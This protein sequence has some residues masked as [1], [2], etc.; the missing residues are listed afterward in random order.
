[1][2]NVGAGKYKGF[3]IH[4]QF[5]DFA[6]SHVQHRLARACETICLFTIDNGPRLV[7][8]VH[9]RAV[10]NTGASLFMTTT[11]AQIPIPECKYRFHL[12]E[13]LRAKRCFNK[14]PGIRR[15]VFKR[16]FETFVM[17]HFSFYLVAAGS[18]RSSAR[19]LTTICAPCA[20]NS[21]ALFFL[22]T[23]IT[24]PKPPCAPARTPEIASSITTAR[25]GATPSISAA[26]RK[27]SGAG[28][29]ARP[30]A[31]IKSPSTR[32]SK[33]S[34]TL[35]ALRMA[36]QF[37]LEVTMAVLICKCRKYLRNATEPG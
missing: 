19:S 30:S 6:I 14:I 36:S 28:L 18:M 3:V 37:W 32:T 2:T 35:A 31:A 17:K 33:K 23:P 9:K 21:S 34:S 22:A 5:D 15:I 26:F 16:R 7:K 4:I 11:H 13:E 29:P 20:F 8:S 1:M 10:L 24:R 27:E 25:L 12:R